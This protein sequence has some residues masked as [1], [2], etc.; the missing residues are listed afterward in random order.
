MV[1]RDDIILVFQVS[2][3][4]A[5]KS[6]VKGKSKATVPKKSIPSDKR[7]KKKSVKVI[8]LMHMLNCNVYYWHLE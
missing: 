4:I 8:T 7:P 3:A 5:D 6:S 1:K 2:N